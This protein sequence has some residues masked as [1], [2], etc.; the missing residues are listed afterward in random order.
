M[1][2]LVG[3]LA[4]QGKHKFAAI[5]R[6]VPK[7][8]SLDAAT[9]KNATQNNLASVVKAGNALVTV[10]K[11]KSGANAKKGND[12]VQEDLEELFLSIARCET[13]FF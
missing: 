2:T 10:K 13:K 4:E 12:E 6:I 8:K 1:D 11:E 3:K 9:I 7:K 5:M